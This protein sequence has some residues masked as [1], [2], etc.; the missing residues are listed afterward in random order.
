MCVCCII[1]FTRVERSEAA[2]KCNFIV[3]TLNKFPYKYREK[4]RHKVFFC[5]SQT[6][7]QNSPDHVA[8]QTAA[9]FMCSEN[10]MKER[11]QK[12]RRSTTKTT[13]AEQEWGQ[14][15]RCQG[16]APKEALHRWK[17]ARLIKTGLS[18]QQK[19]RK[20][21]VLMLHDERKQRKRGQKYHM[22]LNLIGY[23][24]QKS[25]RGWSVNGHW[26]A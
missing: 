11:L 1:H 2:P 5:C 16:P 25:S 18:M 6:R 24:L 8:R 12:Q 20:K 17:D 26:S 21:M 7:S 3:Y 22:K 23:T 4:E 19:G 10:S 9:A 13:A 14:F 15:Y